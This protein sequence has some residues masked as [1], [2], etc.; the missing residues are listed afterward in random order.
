M[1][2]P[3][4]GAD[5]AIRAAKELEGT[6]IKVRIIGR[7]L[8]KKDME[9]LVQELKPTNVELITEMLPI[10]ELRKKMLECHLSL[11]QLANHPRVHTTIPHKVF[12]SMAMKLPY[13]TGDNKGVMEFLTDGE[14]CFTV[15]PG[16]Y[17][18]LA[19]KILV[20]KDRP[21]ELEQ[22][23]ENAYQLYQREFPPKIL[24]WKLLEEL[25]GLMK[26]V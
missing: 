15:P 8:L 23:A 10:E 17:H 22:V 7:G 9:N 12:E 24:A 3:E 11:G 2:L 5:I 13:L 6:G 21:K 4:A 16:D 14:T 20:L 25:Q 26:K 19:R 1:F 18:A